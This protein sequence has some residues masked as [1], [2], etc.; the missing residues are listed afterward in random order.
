MKTN[1]YRIIF[2]MLFLWSQNWIN[3]KIYKEERVAKSWDLG[4]LGSESDPKSPMTNKQNCSKMLP[5]TIVQSMGIA[6]EGFH[7]CRSWLEGS[8]S[9]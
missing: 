3:L 4:N 9:S 2:N 8:K 7:R 1:L 5:V 6:L